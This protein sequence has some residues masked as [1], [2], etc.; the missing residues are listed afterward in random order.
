MARAPTKALTKAPTK[1]TTKTAKAK[2]EAFTKNSPAKNRRSAPVKTTPTPVK[3]TK[4]A[5]PSKNGPIPPLSVLLE[6]AND[7]EM[8]RRPLGYYKPVV[9]VLISKGMIT[10]EILDWLEAHNVG[11]YPR[12]TIAKLV[13]TIK[14]EDKENGCVGLPDQEIDPT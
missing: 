9:R 3:R 10:L 13:K 8:L 11:T 12:T 2:A 14:D 4:I 6:K 1:E 5:I 7:E